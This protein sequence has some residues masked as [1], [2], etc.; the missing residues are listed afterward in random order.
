MSRITIDVVLE[1]RSVS[2][3]QKIRIELESHGRCRVFVGER[4]ITTSIAHLVL[5]VDPGRTTELRL[6][7]APAAIEV[8][9][10]ADK[11]TENREEWPPKLQHK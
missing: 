9:G 6:T 11:I 2:A 8:T 1:L 3:P 5:I 10:E 7:L 4:E